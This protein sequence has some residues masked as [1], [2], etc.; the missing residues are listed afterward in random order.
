MN[1]YE[2]WAMTRPRNWVFA[3][4]DA[5]RQGTWVQIAR[6]QK[7]SSSRGLYLCSSKRQLYLGFWI[8]L[9]W[10]TLPTCIKLAKCRE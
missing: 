3:T 8:V 7:C 4:C 6:G 9:H 1:W 5:Q 10:A 2:H